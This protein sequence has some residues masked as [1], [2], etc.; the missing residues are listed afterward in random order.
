MDCAA[1]ALFHLHATSGTGGMMTPANLASLGW[2]EDKHG[3]LLA[4]KLPTLMRL[5]CR[6]CGGDSHAAMAEKV[7][8]DLPTFLFFLDQ[9]AVGSL[10]GNVGSSGSG[11]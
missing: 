11:M 1:K 8:W 4:A 6:A 5:A 3:V 9:Q 10:V 2:T 7:A